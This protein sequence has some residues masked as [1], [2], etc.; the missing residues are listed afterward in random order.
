MDA[1]LPA[2]IRDALLTTKALQNDTD[3]FFGSEFTPGFAFDLPNDG[4]RR[5]LGLFL[6]CHAFLL[7]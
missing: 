3:L 5:S 6:C 4:F 2:E 1:F 7:A